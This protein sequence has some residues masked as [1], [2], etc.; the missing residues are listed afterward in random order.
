ME[1]LLL[2]LATAAEERTG[3]HN[4]EG[5]CLNRR[6]AHALMA[7]HLTG[8]YT[9]KARLNYRMKILRNRGESDALCPTAYSTSTP[10]VHALHRLL[11]EGSSLTPSVPERYVRLLA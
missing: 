2:L 4:S 10:F 3:L 6:L 8:Y 7:S 11:N 5:G 1:P 9:Q